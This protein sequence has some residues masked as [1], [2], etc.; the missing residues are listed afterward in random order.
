M[1]CFTG[2]PTVIFPTQIT[3]MLNSCGFQD[4]GIIQ[5]IPDSGY[6]AIDKRKRIEKYVSPVSHVSMDLNKIR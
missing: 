1:R 5:E 3:G 2:T 6:N 4:P